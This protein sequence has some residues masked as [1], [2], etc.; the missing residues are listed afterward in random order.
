M[1]ATIENLAKCEV[2]G[3]IRF[4]WDKK[5]SALNAH[6]ELCAICELNNMSED[7]ERKWMEHF[8]QDG[9]TNIHRELQRGKPSEVSADLLKEIDEKIRLFCNFTISQLSE[10]Y[11]NISLTVLYEKVMGALG[12]RK[13]CVRWIP[14]MLTEIHKTSR[15]GRPP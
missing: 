9:R 11:P 14:K 15:K 10:H 12:Y 5:L 1:R 6:L 2:R 4:L 13:F 3:V 7:V 8:F